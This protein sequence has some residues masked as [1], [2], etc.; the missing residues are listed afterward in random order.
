L[1]MSS[2]FAAGL[3]LH[4][5]FSKAP[6]LP[7]SPREK[8]IRRY[9]KT[10][11]LLSFPMSRDFYV[12]LYTTY[13]IKFFESCFLPLTAISPTQA[14]FVRHVIP[15][16]IF[17]HNYGAFVR[18]SGPPDLLV[19]GLFVVLHLI[20]QFSSD[21]NALGL[22]SYNFFSPESHKIFFSRYNPFGLDFLRF[23]PILESPQIIVIRYPP[24]PHTF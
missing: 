13:F 21:L 14:G 9:P 18:V 22:P 8:G 3:V 1:Y 12:P 15:R 10:H 5:F 2:F 6:F 20:G 16:R 23:T 19:R 7:P 17:S 24:H 4:G 11:P